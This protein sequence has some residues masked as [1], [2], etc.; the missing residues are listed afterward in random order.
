M[1]KSIFW[2]E[3]NVRSKFT[4]VRSSHDLCARAHTH[5]LEGTLD[6]C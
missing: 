4:Y 6:T 3:H 1:C 2:K 5:N